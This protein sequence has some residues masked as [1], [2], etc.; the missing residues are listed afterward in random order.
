MYQAIALKID[1]LPD[2]IA[3]VI[4]A[5]LDDSY[6]HEIPSAAAS[7][8]REE[9]ELLDWIFQNSIEVREIQ[10]LSKKSQRFSAISAFDYAMWRLAIGIDK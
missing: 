1:D 10:S 9:S 5:R 2:C 8:G 3:P 7:V 6:W 4:V